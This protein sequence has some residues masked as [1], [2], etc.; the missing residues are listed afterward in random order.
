MSMTIEGMTGNPLVVHLSRIPLLDYHDFRAGVCELVQEEGNH[1]VIYYAYPDHDRLRFICCIANDPEHKIHILSHEQNAFPIPSLDPITKEH[2]AF[3]CFERELYEQYNVLFPGHPW[4]KPLRHQEK[5]GYP[6][7]SIDGGELH[8]VG[9]GPVH[10]GVIEPG[11][12]RFLCNGEKV[13]HLEIQLGYQH[14]GVEKL[15]LAKPSGIQRSVLSENI[16]GDTAIGHSIAYAQLVEGLAGLNVNVQLQKERI[17]ALE[18]ERLAVHIGDTAALCTDVA[19]QLGQAVNEALRTIL[20]NTTQNWCGNRFGKGLVRPGGSNYP[21]TGELSEKIL[22]NLKEVEE[23]YLQ[24][25]GEIFTNPSVL[26]RYESTGRVTARQAFQIGAVG[27]AARSSG[28]KRDTRW[29]HPFQAFSKMNYEP[30]VLK[31]GD[32]WARAM[33]RKLEAVRSISII[34]DLLKEGTTTS[35]INPPVY[36]PNLHP[37]SFV[38]SMTEGWRGEIVHSGVTDEQ[39]RIIHYKV[40]DP[41]FH[42]WMALALA[43]RNQEISDFPLCNKSY[44]LSYCGHDL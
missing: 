29:S 37:D 35:I 32:V 25:T 8:E 18:M 13:L 2:P 38:I 24:M 26:S 27:M 19:Y 12:F 41:S 16:A 30:E 21:M 15:Y 5:P 34:R 1:C 3:H 14:R 39:G 20:I 36:D 44:N 42:N 22:T 7:F 23:R 4:L 10:A 17:I 11:Y 43:V 9:V 31:T 33:L 40:K 6:F 28:L